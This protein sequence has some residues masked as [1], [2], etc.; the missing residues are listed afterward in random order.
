VSRRCTGQRASACRRIQKY[1]LGL[2]GQA[3]LLATAKVL[4]DKE[5]ESLRKGKKEG[6]K[7]R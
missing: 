4:S 7:S 2:L 5:V 1:F 6:K 3:R